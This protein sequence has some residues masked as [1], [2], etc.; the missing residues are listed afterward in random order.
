MKNSMKK[1]DMI[2]IAVREVWKQWSYLE[3]IKWETISGY[4]KG[5]FTIAEADKLLED[6]HAYQNAL[7]AWYGMSE[8]ADRMGIDWLNEAYSSGDQETVEA[9]ERHDRFSRNTWNWYKKTA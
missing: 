1:S 4:D 5:L 9:V 7:S 8:L 2:T 6:D 3:E